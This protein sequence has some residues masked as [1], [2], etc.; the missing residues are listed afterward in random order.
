MEQYEPNIRHPQFNPAQ[1]RAASRI[2]S[3]TL[4]N[5]ND[6]FDGVLPR[7]FR[8]DADRPVYSFADIMRL[9][10]MAELT[11]LGHTPARAAAAAVQ[12]TERGAFGASRDPDEVVVIRDTG[13]L[14]ESGA[15]ALALFAP[16]ERQKSGCDV[17]NPALF[18]EVMSFRKPGLDLGAATA[19]AQPGGADPWRPLSSR[20]S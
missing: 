11:R 16:T 15:T 8:D 10:I 19:V 3:K 14:F 17:V 4:H 20:L 12:F 1:A 13:M 9:A 7:I 5:W 6:R 18:A 2:D